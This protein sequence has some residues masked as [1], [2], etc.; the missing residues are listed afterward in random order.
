MLSEELLS[1]LLIHLTLLHL[2]VE[3]VFVSLISVEPE[4]RY[5]ASH[6]RL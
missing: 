6:L 3:D 2:Y 5:F 4:N 1:I